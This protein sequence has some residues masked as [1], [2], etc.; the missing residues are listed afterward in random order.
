[1]WDGANDED[2]G[3]SGCQQ[4]VEAQKRRLAREKE[5]LLEEQKHLLE[6]NEYL[7]ALLANHNIPCVAR[8]GYDSA[9]MLQASTSVSE[10]QHASNSH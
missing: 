7:K 6:E 3:P 5:Y 8:Y 9:T 1:M 2:H 10:A 4:P